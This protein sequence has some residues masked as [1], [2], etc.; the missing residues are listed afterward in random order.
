MRWNDGRWL[1]LALALGCSDK[2]DTEEGSVPSAI[3]WAGWNHTWSKLSHRVSFI[4]AI[5]EPDGGLSMGIRGGDWSTGDTWADDAAYRMQLQRVYGY[6]LDIVH[7]E[8][9]LTVGPEGVATVEDSAEVTSEQVVVVLRGFEIETDVAQG[10]DYPDDYDPAL[11]YTSRGFGMEVGGA[12]ADGS[13]VTF[14]V[15]AAIRWGPRDRDDMNAA[16][17]LAETGVRVAWTVIGYSGAESHISLSDAVDLSHSP[18]YSTQSGLEI[19]TELDGGPGIIG[20]TAFDLGVRDQDGGPGGDYLRSFGVEAALDDGDAPEQ[21]LAEVT[22]SS[23]IELGTMHFA[24]EIDL[25][26]VQPDSKDLRIETFSSEGT[27]EV[28]SFEIDPTD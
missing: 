11:G 3:V 8:T 18:P 6:G 16:M 21:V 23:A 17:P 12:T 2:G 22:T 27:H 1:L 4:Q 24:P 9:S 19:S 14:D 15:T 26:W 13:L 5:A 20:L 10:A 28:G 25:V 7:G